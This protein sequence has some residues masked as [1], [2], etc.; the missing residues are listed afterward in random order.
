LSA[1]AE[2]VRRWGLLG[3]IGLV[4]AAMAV[5][6]LVHWL[7]APGPISFL[8]GLV[9]YTKGGAA[10]CSPVTLTLEAVEVQPWLTNSAPPQVRLTVGLN[11]SAWSL[12]TR[13]VTTSPDALAI[14]PESILIYT[15]EPP[16]ELELDLKVPNLP[17]PGFFSRRSIR[18]ES[19]PLPSA[20]V[21]L[22]FATISTVL[23]AEPTAHVRIRI[24]PR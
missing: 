2:I 3:L 19:L 24:E 16:F 20:E 14:N 17:Y 6:L 18:I 5:G 13:D 8:G 7:A 9:Q 15:P 4:V 23:G 12:P 21:R 10:V 22:P 1:T 11:G